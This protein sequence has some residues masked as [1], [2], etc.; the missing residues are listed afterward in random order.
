[1]KSNYLL[2][3][4][5][6][7]TGWFLAIPFT[8]LALLALSS[9][10]YF[11]TLNCPQLAIAV[12]NFG[13]TEYFQIVQTNIITTI[14]LVGL[15]VALIFIAFSREK[16]EDEY[17]SKIRERSLVWSVVANY[18]VLCAASVFLFEM[19]FLSF[20]FINMYLLLIIFICKFNYEL[21]KFK[22]SAENEQ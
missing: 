5:F 10:S 17:I 6:K 12:D 7:K 2:P 3:T 1:M 21:Y 9:S 14:T 11:P 18:I 4:C 8:L 15:V 16:I 22:K 13:H 20:V 19:A